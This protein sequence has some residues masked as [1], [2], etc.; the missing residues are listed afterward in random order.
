MSRPRRIGILGGSF[1]PVHQGHLHAARSARKAFALDRVVFIPAGESPHKIGRERAPGPHRLAMLEV[2]IRG[3]PDFA[4]CDIELARGGTSYTIDTVRALREHLG[5]PPDSELHLVLGSDNV[6]GLPTWRES[7]ALLDLV[8]PVVVHREGD[9]EVLLADLE[10][11]LG[12]ALA[13]KVRAGWLRLPPLPASS[14]DLRAQLAG[15][16]LDDGDVERAGLEP[17]VLE[18]IRAH[19]LYGTRSGAG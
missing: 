8:Q 2:A 5:E 13:S 16:A 19:G 6:P 17:L 1:D 4:T 12:S 3:E 9:A 7:R 15:L 18:Y 14:T 11:A 10:R